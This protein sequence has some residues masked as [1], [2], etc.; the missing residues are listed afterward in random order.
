[1]LEGKNLVVTGCL[2]GIGRQT[3]KAFAENGA[4]VVA[5]A[6]ERTDEF[7]TFCQE[8]A[9]ENGVNIIPVYFDMAEPETIRSAARKIQSEKID[10]HGLVNIA[11]INR[12][13]YFN[14]MTMKDLEETFQ[15]NFFSQMLFTQYVVKLMLRK[16]TSGSIAFTSS[17]SALDGNEGQVAYSASKAALLGAM[18][19]MAKELGSFGIRVNAVA[20]GVIRTPMTE[21]LSD[22]LKES[23]IRM[24]DIK[25]LGE[26]DE[27]AGTFVYLMSDLSSHITGQTIRIDGGMRG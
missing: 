10:I 12:D 26:A 7:E 24:M 25:R 16:K 18:R 19:S 11:G 6:Y 21:K 8:L 9:A 1:M 4:S 14:M 17:V 3:L 27:V 22:G 23:R 5:C 20:P 15:V 13:A 2:S